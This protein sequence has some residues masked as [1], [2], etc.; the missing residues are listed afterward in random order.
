MSP[1]AGFRRGHFSSRKIKN[2]KKMK[3][4]AILTEVWAASL[5]ETESTQ[6]RGS[7][8]PWT[9]LRRPFL[10]EPWRRRTPPT[11]GCWG[12]DTRVKRSAETRSFHPL[13]LNMKVRIFE[14]FFVLDG[15]ILQQTTSVTFK[16]WLDSGFS[17]LLTGSKL[18]I[19]SQIIHKFPLNLLRSAAEGSRKYFNLTRPVNLLLVI[20]TDCSWRSCQ[21]LLDWPTLFGPLR[22]KETGSDVQE[23]SRNHQQDNGPEHQN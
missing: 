7:S 21:H 4:E 6:S 11:P 18:H 2:L 23:Q 1:T 8:A 10:C 13:I 9:G 3:P 19:Q 12:G 15:L 22:W 20:M 17:L 14:P 16:V 5:L